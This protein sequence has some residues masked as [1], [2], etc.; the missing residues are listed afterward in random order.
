MKIFFFVFKPYVPSL[1]S[2][3]YLSIYIV[4][5][6]FMILAIGFF[7]A[8]LYIKFRDIGSLWRVFTRALF[9][10][11]PIIWTLSLLPVQYH[12]FILMN[13]LAFAIHFT[14]VG[15]IDNHNPSF[16]QLT[17]FMGTIFIFFA[18]SI[19][20]YNKTDKKIVESL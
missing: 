15:L 8:P 20:T 5:I 14:K 3:G 18:L 16:Q 4:A 9:Y 6:F 17:L 10:A 1:I 7:L 19:F 11:T 13:P 12:K 2:L